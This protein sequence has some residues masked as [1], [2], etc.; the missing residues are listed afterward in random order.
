MLFE[1]I[2]SHQQILCCRALVPQQNKRLET[3]VGYNLR[4]EGDYGF[5]SGTGKKQIN[6]A[7]EWSR[8]LVKPSPK[9]YN[10]L[11]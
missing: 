11:A 5:Y 8:H 9:L 7:F 10:R 6:G 4:D 1:Q 2:I 3:N